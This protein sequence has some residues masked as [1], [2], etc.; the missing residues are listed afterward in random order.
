MSKAL[1]KHPSTFQSLWARSRGT[2][3]NDWADLPELQLSIID[4]SDNALGSSGS[5][6]FIAQRDVAYVVVCDV[7]TD[8]WRSDLQTWLQH[9]SS[10]TE[11]KA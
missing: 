6:P 3:C 5:L 2:P 11:S 9:V 1:Q 8:D 4:A 7:T 10:H